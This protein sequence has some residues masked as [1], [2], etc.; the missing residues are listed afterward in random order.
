MPAS[1]SA[2]H[3]AFAFARDTINRKYDQLLPTLEG[4]AD[5]SFQNDLLNVAH[6]AGASDLPQAQKDQLLHVIQNK[7]MRKFSQ[8][9]TIS[10]HALKD[11]ESELGASFATR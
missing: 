1:V 11:V 4:H 2:G 10:G 9:G 7:V 5:P 3:D 8:N 6:L